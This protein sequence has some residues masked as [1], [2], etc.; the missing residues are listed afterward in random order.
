MMPS[1]FRPALTT[2]TSERISTMTPL[3][4]EPGLSLAMDAWVDS[5]S[6]ANDSVMVVSRLNIRATGLPGPPVVRRCAWM[7]AP[8]GAGFLPG[9]SSRTT[10]R[11]RNRLAGLSKCNRQHR[12]HAFDHFGDRRAGGVHDDRV[13]GGLQGR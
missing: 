13:F 8:E 7:N 1:D 10:R 4:M 2:M 9:I 6:S 11:W 3:T 5:N 12:Q